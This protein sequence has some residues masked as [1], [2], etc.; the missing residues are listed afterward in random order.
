[1]LLFFLNLLITV[2]KFSSETIGVIFIKLIDYSGKLPS[3]PV[4]KNPKFAACV[5][6]CL[7]FYIVYFHL[8]SLKKGCNYNNDSWSVGPWCNGRGGQYR[9]R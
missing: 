6:I 2:C 1:M 8:N 7:S 4:K 5:Y 3:G 9:I